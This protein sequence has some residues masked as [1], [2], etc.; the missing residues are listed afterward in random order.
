MYDNELMHYGIKGMKW[1]V[2][3]YQNK[4]G[5]LTTAG[6]KRALKEEYKKVGASKQLTNRY[7]GWQDKD[8][9]TVNK[10][11][12]ALD[13]L[14]S[15]DSNPKYTDRQRAKDYDTAIRGMTE[16]RDRQVLRGMRE[17]AEYQYL[18]NK[19]ARLEDKTVSNPKRQE[20]IDK[21][22]KS[23]MTDQ[24][25]ARLGI[26]EATLRYGQNAAAVDALV[27]RM[28]ND[29]AVVYTTRR[30]VHANEEAGPVQTAYRI[31]SAGGSSVGADYSYNSISGTDYK[32]KANTKRRSSSKKYNDPNRKKQYRSTIT[33]HDVNYYY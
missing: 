11:T 10:V 15:G 32:V 29:K 28:S 14:D 6:K 2:R 7:I 30:R 1:G 20:K 19:L 33:R 3:R 5:S 17:H 25:L 16:L 26:H 23:I 27:K 12:K 9:K 24:K 4:D 22:I 18:N 13:R 8:V 31:D 21:K